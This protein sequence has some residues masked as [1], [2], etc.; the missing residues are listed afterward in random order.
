MRARIAGWL[1]AP[2]PVAPGPL[3]GEADLD[4]S[5]AVRGLVFRLTEALGVLPRKEAGDLLPSVGKDDRQRLRRWACGS[6][7]PP[8]LS[9]AG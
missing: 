7:A 2:S 3:G 8:C 1:R 9:P 6:G 4:L 5:P